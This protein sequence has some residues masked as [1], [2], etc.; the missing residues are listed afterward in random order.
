MFSRDIRD[1]SRVQDV[2]KSVRLSASQIER[3]P[4]E[5]G[6][7]Y[8]AT[9]GTKTLV[10]TYYAPACLASGYEQVTVDTQNGS[11]TCQYG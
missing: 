7:S 11:D 8:V 6:V 9:V 1:G 3:L 10:L 5:I 4:L 2:R